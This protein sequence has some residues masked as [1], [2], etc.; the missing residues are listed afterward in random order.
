MLVLDSSMANCILGLRMQIYEAT[1]LPIAKSIW[2]ALTTLSIIS[3]I[4]HTVMLLNLVK[5]FGLFAM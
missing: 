5:L 2:A 3:L 1:L 4:F